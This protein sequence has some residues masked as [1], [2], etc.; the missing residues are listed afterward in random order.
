MFSSASACVLIELS[1]AAATAQ[2]LEV[3]HL[4]RISASR[5][6]TTSESATRDRRKLV[7]ER[8]PRCPSASPR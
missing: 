1:A 5:G 7:A 3:L 4:I 2:P 8:L 6:E